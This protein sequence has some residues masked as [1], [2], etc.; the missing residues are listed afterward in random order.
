MQMPPLPDGR[1][2]LPPVGVN[3]AHLP[4]VKG[5]LAHH[6]VHTS[7]RKSVARYS[8]TPMGAKPMVW[9]RLATVQRNGTV[10]IVYP[11]AGIPNPYR[12]GVVNTACNAIQWNDSSTWAGEVLLRC[13]SCDR[14]ASPGVVDEP[15]HD[16]FHLSVAG[17]SAS[18]L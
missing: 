6:R 12:M 11:D 16:A 5:S 10:N 18:H 7:A 14:F 9:R 4:A 17:R 2:G 15:R 1:F 3:V 13:L 8:L